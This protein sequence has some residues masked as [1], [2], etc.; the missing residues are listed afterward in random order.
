MSGPTYYEAVEPATPTSQNSRHRAVHSIT[1]NASGIADSTI[2]YGTIDALRSQ[3]GHF[4]PPPSETPTPTTPTASGFSFPVPIAPLNLPQRNPHP[5]VPSETSHGPQPQRHPLAHY[6]TERPTP[7]D[8]ALRPLRRQPS[9]KTYATNGTVGSL[10]PFD[11]HEGSSSIDVDPHD[12][13]MLPTSFITSLIS[14]SERGSLRSNPTTMSPFQNSAQLFSGGNDH[15]GASSISDATYPPHDYPPFPSPDKT[16]PPGA[17]YLESSG[18]SSKT[19]TVGTWTLDAGHGEPSVRSHTPF[20]NAAQK[21]DPIEE[22]TMGELQARGEASKHSS[23]INPS[24]RS[25]RGRRQSLTS[26]RTTKSYVSSLISKLSRAASRRF[27]TKPLPPV[28]AI[29]GELRDSDYQKFEDAM[30][31][32]QLANRADVLSK[33]LAKGHRPYSDYSPSNVHRSMPDTGMEIPWDG[34]TQTRGAAKSGWP[35]IHEASAYGHHPEEKA[36]SS[37]RPVG[38]WE[39]L[40]TRF[41]KKRIVATLIVIPALLIILAVLLGVLLSRKSTGLPDCPAGKTGTD[42]DIGT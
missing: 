31:L 39:R 32:P 8:G 17:A 21:Y 30:P 2:S 33:M 35:A 3:L 24:K 7:A 15:D 16:T 12:D 27:A 28:P 26:T 4:P 29:P 34:V 11:W 42:C 25:S 40:T 14:S 38:F 41:G 10:S 6:L 37:E 13:R 18:R 5:D 19:S 20:I 9:F 1:T 23:G 22:D 36:A